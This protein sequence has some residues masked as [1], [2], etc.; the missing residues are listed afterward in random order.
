M[1]AE[2]LVV[3]GAR[4]NF[5]KVAPVI[6]AL[7]EGGSTTVRVLNT[8][9]HY[10]HRLAG[11]F[12]EQLDFP[13]VEFSLGIGSGTHAEQTAAV[14]VGVERVLAE[15]SFDA[16][17]VPGDVNSTMAAALAA[18]KLRVPVVHLEAGLRSGD[19]EMP[20]EINRIVTDR[21]SNLLLCHSPEAI[22]NL[23]REGVPADRVELV[24]NTMIDSLF[25]LLPAARETGVVDRLGLKDGGFGL[26]TLHRPA[27]V[28]DPGRLG[29]VLEVLRELSKRLPLVMPLHPRT[30]ARLDA[31]EDGALG[32]IVALE[33]LEYMEFV[34]LEASARMVVT[35]S[36][37]VQ[38]ETSV[39]GV[40]C[41]TYR[42]TTERP[43]TV[44]QGTNRLV[45][46]APDL[47]AVA[48]QEVLDAEMPA[49][50]PEIPLWDGAAGGRAAAAIEAALMR[51]EVSAA[52]R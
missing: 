46:V 18:V 32:G 34:S 37:G 49:Q 41:I 3:V 44:T 11:S 19:E 40:P 20:E 33:P 1:T 31:Q 4:P 27:L 45:G 30:R 14:M 38:E 21:V 13:P 23:A 17:M 6:H 2:L 5:V 35:D 43:L 51:W 52:V 25:A 42:T 24:G 39:L 26:V 50:A 28:D 15:G 29:A 48:C 16:V 9:Q 47:L 7:A 8:G 10:D 36:G 12:L 22:D